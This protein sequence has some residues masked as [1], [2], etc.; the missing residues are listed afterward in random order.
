MSI[1]SFSVIRVIL[2]WLVLVG[3]TQSIMTTRVNAAS[4]EPLPFTGYVQYEGQDT[5]IPLR[6]T[7]ISKYERLPEDNSIVGSFSAIVT[8]FL[9]AIDG[10]E[11][12]PMYYDRVDYNPYTKQFRLETSYVNHPRLTF[13]WDFVADEVHGE[14]LTT[15]LQNGQFVRGH[16]LVRRGWDVPARTV[17]AGSP[18]IPV[19]G[20]YSGHCTSTSPGSNVALRNIQLFPSRFSGSVQRP[21]DT[22]MAAITYVGNLQCIRGSDVSTQHVCGS[23]EAVINIYSN[24]LSIASSHHGIFQCKRHASTGSLTCSGDRFSQCHLARE[25]LP[26]QKMMNNKFNITSDLKNTSRPKSPAIEPE[27]G[28]ASPKILDR[29][30]FEVRCA[31]WEGN[32][33]AVVTHANSGRQQVMTLALLHYVS[34]DAR[35]RRCNVSGAISISIG[36]SIE[37][38]ERLV[39]MIPSTDVDVNR[40]NVA[41]K[42]Q[43]DVDRL[44]VQLNK[45]NTKATQSSGKEA[46]HGYL[47]FSSWGYVGEFIA[48]KD[49]DPTQ[50]A[51]SMAK[52]VSALTAEHWSDEFDSTRSIS[53]SVVARS[54]DRG[55]N[56]PY[57]QLLVQGW[58]QQQLSTP[59][60]AINYRENLGGV[61]YD[62]FTNHF[63]MRTD[64]LFVVGTFVGE[65]M[66][67]LIAVRKNGA[68]AKEPG[69]I[70]VLAKHDH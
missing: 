22:T 68:L 15:S 48:V 6:I 64:G 46:L 60:G 66:H 29:R 36:R 9:G 19:A 44:I 1:T 14:A 25:D 40:D 37:G 50:L 70:H 5:I 13:N 23:Q 12:I 35:G 45:F 39:Y 8:Y 33:S 56:S 61:S 28:S 31:L 67:T 38:E 34:E 52:P 11:S 58:I 54:L 27:I 59:D 7:L 10:S 62:L 47:Y 55:I 41:I 24:M 2:G 43:G 53:F 21:T 65:A 18:M 32:F 51:A 3:M 17:F 4:M 49:A 69:R 42:T 30:E 16:F 26:I 57:A 20:I 63:T